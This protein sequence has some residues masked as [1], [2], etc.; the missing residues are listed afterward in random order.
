MSS[1]QLVVGPHSSSSLIRTNSVFTVEEITVNNLN[2]T[3][4]LNFTGDLI[5]NSLGVTTDINTNGV[6]R[7][8]GTEVLNTTTLGSGILASSLTS[9]GELTNLVV[10]GDIDAQTVKKQIERTKHYISKTPGAIAVPVIVTLYQDEIDFIGRVPIVPIFQFSSF[11]DEF[12][13]N[14]EEMKTIESN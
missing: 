5:V 6:Y 12:Y 11:V 7:V 8:D 13:G 2:I 9:V 14:L 10:I 1:A 3:S 4:A